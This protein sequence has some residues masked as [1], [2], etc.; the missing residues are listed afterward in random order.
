MEGL[1]FPQPSQLYFIIMNSSHYS[2]KIKKR[3]QLTGEVVK[4][5]NQEV[6]EFQ[7]QGQTIYADFLETLSYG[8]YLTLYLGLRYDQNPAINPWVDYFKSELAK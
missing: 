8:S 7:P 1:Q 3:M 2:E 4:K 6:M 5:N